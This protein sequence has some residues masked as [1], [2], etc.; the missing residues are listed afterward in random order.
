MEKNGKKWKKYSCEFCTYTT[1]RKKDYDKHVST[2]KHEKMGTLYEKNGK[3]HTVLHQCDACGYNT[4]VSQNY[5]KH[6]L[7][8][9][10]TKMENATKSNTFSHQPETE[11]K[12]EKK[13]VFYNCIE[14]N[15]NTKDKT[16]YGKHCLTKKHIQNIENI[17]KRKSEI[18]EQP[19]P[20]IELPNMNITEPNDNSNNIVIDKNMFF[21]LLKQGNDFKQMFLQHIEQTNKL[22]D[23]HSK[24]NTIINNNNTNCNNRFNLSLFLNEQCKDAMNINE[25]IESIEIGIDDL[26]YVGKHGYISGITKIVTNSLNQLGIYKRPIHCTDLKREIIHIKEEDKWKKDNEEHEMTNKMIEKVAYKNLKLVSPWQKKHPECQVL[27]SPEYNLW[28]NIAKQSNGGSD[29]D[30]NVNQVL[31]NISKMVYIDKNEIS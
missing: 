26:E 14:C 3:S 23:I 7:T 29:V 16:N 21:E 17:E 20:N 13:Y 5:E 6:I 28:W 18:V 8:R 12:P 1:S 4:S 22:V 24:G 25:F 30:K 27:D 11:E 9:K 31:K 10:H 19:I 15:F 2:R